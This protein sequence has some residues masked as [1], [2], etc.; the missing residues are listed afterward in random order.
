MVYENGE[1]SDYSGAD[2]YL[3]GDQIIIE[4]NYPNNRDFYV[5]ALGLGD[6]IL[7]YSRIGVLICG[8]ETLSYTTESSFDFNLTPADFG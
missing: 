2:V 6:T 4:T 8:S 1:F 3:S 5:I 7:N